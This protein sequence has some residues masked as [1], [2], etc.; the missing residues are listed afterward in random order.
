[1]ALRTIDDLFEMLPASASIQ[2]PLSIG[3]RTGAS[4]RR[5]KSMNVH[6]QSLVRYCCCL[7]T[8]AV[9]RPNEVRRSDCSQAASGRS[10]TQA[11]ASQKKSCA[12]QGE[13]AAAVAQQAW[14][15]FTSLPHAWSASQC[16]RGR[17]PRSRTSATCSSRMGDWLHRIRHIPSGPDMPDCPQSGK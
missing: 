5:L 7:I 12:A 6:L 3:A 4:G 15:K 8:I 10:R 14:R 17:P 11:C 13:A 16:W 9:F 2:G 1:M